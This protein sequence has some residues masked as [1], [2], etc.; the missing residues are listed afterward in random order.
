MADHDESKHN[1][2]AWIGGGILIALGAIFLLQRFGVSFPANW[3][4]IFIAV[5][6]VGALISA[7][8]SYQR[9]GTI[10]GKARGALISGVILAVI[11]IALFF[12][13]D[14]GA[15]WPILLILLGVVVIAGNYWRGG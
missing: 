8:R 7:W 2:G 15:I 9:D 11:A 14:L 1:S 5:P 13:V 10:A 12:G 3:W 4:A 6:A